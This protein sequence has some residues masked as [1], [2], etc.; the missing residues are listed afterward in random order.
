MFTVIF[1][2]TY[3]I[4]FRRSIGLHLNIGYIEINFHIGCILFYS[5]IRYI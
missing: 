1:E 5:N 4:T 3:S 2:F